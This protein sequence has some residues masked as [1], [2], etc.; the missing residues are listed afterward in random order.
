[1]PALSALEDARKRAYVAGIHVFAVLNEDMG[2]NSCLP[3]FRS[4]ESRNVG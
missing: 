3:E 2:T 1:M 4:I